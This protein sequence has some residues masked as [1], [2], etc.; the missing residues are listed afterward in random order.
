[1][2]REQDIRKEV[3]LQLHA[4]RPLPASASLISRQAVKSGL[5]FTPSEVGRECVFLLDQ[6]LVT[7]VQDPVSGEQKYRITA[8]GVITHEQS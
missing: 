4:M 7:T 5:D 3:L 2:T 8:K 1:M 6:G